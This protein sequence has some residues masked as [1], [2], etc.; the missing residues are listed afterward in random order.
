MKWLRLSAQCLD[1]IE[2]RYALVGGL[3]VGVRVEPRFTRDVDL[4]IDVKTDADAEAVAAHLIHSG[5]RLLA[6][7]DHTVSNRIA[8][9]RML[10]PGV[11]PPVGDED[12]SLLVDLRFSTSGIEAEVVAGAERRMVQVGLVVPVAR[13]EHL[14]AMKTVSV[15]DARRQDE[16]DLHHLLERASPRQVD[17]ARRLID[18]VIARGLHRQRDLHATLNHFLARAKRDR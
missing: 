17:A 10:P 18:L 9:L 11:D 5:F 13:A 1:E 16:V 7:M 8:T 15:C 4:A 6:E 12:P 14:I 2:A 3:A